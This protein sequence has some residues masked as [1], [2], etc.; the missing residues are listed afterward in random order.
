[1]WYAFWSVVHDLWFFVV[2][3][4][5]TARPLATASYAQLP[6]PLSRLQLADVT[7][8]LPLVSTSVP[9]IPPVITTASVGSTISIPTKETS[10]LTADDDATRIV[11]PRARLHEPSILYVSA[12]AGTVCLQEPGGVFDA[13]ITT[14]SF[15]TAVTVAGFSGRYAHVQK[16]NY[17][18]WVLKDD[19]TP[20][21]KDVW[22]ELLTWGMY[23]AENPD[24]I[25][26]RALIND[27]FGAG[28]LALPLQAGEYVQLRLLQ[29]KRTIVWPTGRPRLPGGWQSLLKGTLGI[30][31]TITPKTD[32]IMEWQTENDGGRLAY[33]EAVGLDGVITTSCVGLVVAG[34][35]TKQVWGAGDWKELRPTF[36]EV[37]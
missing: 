23:G 27:E 29:D 35:Y 4:F 3:N 30:H 31:S 12:L 1:M 20:H 5:V 21:K 13:I 16:G 17:T 28:A 25:K 19:I 33:V 32:T 14:L 22:P 18:G 26:I 15:G 8:S 7:H 36:I 11:L 6:S 2:G 24:T 37:S 10:H 9:I 34:Q